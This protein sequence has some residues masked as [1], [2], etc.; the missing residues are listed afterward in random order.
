MG[1]KPWYSDDF[2]PTR[3]IKRQNTE[4]SVIASRQSI[5][6]YRSQGSE[7]S[8]CILILESYLSDVRKSL[9]SDLTVHES[10]YLQLPSMKKVLTDCMTISDI[11]L[12]FYRL[13]ETALNFTAKIY[14]ESCDSLI[15]D[16]LQLL[17]KIFSLISC[18]GYLSDTVKLHFRRKKNVSLGESLLELNVRI[19]RVTPRVINVWRKIATSIRELEKVCY[20]FLKFYSEVDGSVP[21]IN[22]EEPVAAMYNYTRN[23]G[24]VVQIVRRTVAYLEGEMIHLKIAREINEIMQKISP[25]VIGSIDKTM[26]GYVIWDLIRYALEYYKNYGMHHYNIDIFEKDLI[27]D[28]HE[29]SVMMSSRTLDQSQRITPVN[30]IGEVASF[31]G[32]KVGKVVTR[33]SSYNDN[34]IKRSRK[35]ASS[36]KSMIYR[37]YSPNK[38]IERRKKN[39]S[40]TVK[41]MKPESVY[42]LYTAE[43]FREFLIEKLKNEHINKSSDLSKRRE[44]LLVEF[45]N[46]MRLIDEEKITELWEDENFTA[47]TLRASSRKSDF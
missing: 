11:S 4:L 39:Q 23:P 45:N 31:H 42:E 18:H 6:T 28:E 5:G 37:E 9:S 12:E 41:V 40:H 25:E 24:H 1:S 2:S 36:N 13:V 38:T 47:E 34:A 30:C 17:Y 46:F 43:R 10:S 7:H 8:V 15:N 21:N 3:R 33:N 26:S 14:E 27:V 20:G 32:K 44:E 19:S 22:F 16:L 29:I 35:H